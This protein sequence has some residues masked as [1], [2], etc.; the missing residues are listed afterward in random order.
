[1]TFGQK[2]ILFSFLLKNIE[3]QHFSGKNFLVVVIQQSHR[4][5]RVKPKYLNANLSGC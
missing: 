5:K 4:L 3:K 2:T 1:M